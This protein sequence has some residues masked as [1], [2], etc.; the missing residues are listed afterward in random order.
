MHFVNIHDAKT[1]LSKYLGIISATHEPI[2]I[3]KNGVPIAQLTEY[4][5]TQ[6]RHLGLCAGTINMTAD[7]DE[8]PAEFMDHFQ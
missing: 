8:M 6:I 2:I 7:F 1:H 5:P 3:C 4:H